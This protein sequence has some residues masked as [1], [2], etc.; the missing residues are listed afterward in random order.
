MTRLYL[1][2]ADVRD[3]DLLVTSGA[4]RCV[5][6]NP[7]LVREAGLAVNLATATHLFAKAQTLGL[8]ELHLQAWP[9]AH[10]NWLPVA[11]EL[12]AL[13]TQVIVKLP[14]IQAALPAART[15]KRQGARVLLTAVN[16]TL[17]GLVAMDLG[18]DYVAPYVGRAQE[19]G[20]DAHGLVDALV[21]LQE[22]GGPC[23]L[24]A[25]IRSQA[26][27]DRLICQGV[28]AVTLRAKLL[29]ELGLDPLT[30]SAIKQFE[31]AL[32]HS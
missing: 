30:V 27:L 28:G 10:G 23:V 3:W 12:A 4:L 16:S 13:G 9:D 32:Q 14:A 20:L 26:M 15:L 8:E 31:D 19:A 7:I 17:Q 2:S 29:R 6:C 25:S 24:A 21:K 22:R 1:D 18:A 5:T 11:L